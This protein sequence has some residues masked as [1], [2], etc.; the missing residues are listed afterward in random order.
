MHMA[1]SMSG[2]VSQPIVSHLGRANAKK[3]D[4]S[5]KVLLVEHTEGQCRA[6]VGFKDG[7]PTAAY[8]C[9][10]PVLRRPRKDSSWCAYHHGQM[11][12][13]HWSDGRSSSQPKAS[14]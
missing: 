1:P 4:G 2:A 10:E 6:I 9:G 7:D 13:S 5:K 14:T 11:H 12:V 3:P 8:M